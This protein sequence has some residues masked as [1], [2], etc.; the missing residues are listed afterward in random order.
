M[1]A[2]R[3]SGTL[4]GAA[5]K[6]VED[7]RFLLGK[8]GY[9]DDWQPAGLV[10]A[11][12]LRS[13]YAHARIAAIDVSRALAL[14]GVIAVVT[15]QQMGELARP[16]RA[17][18]TM[19]TYVA[20]EQPIL[21]RDKVR[22]VGEAVA[23]VVAHSRY[24]A[25]DALE[26]I[27]VE[28]DTLAAVSDVEAAAAEGS[29][30]VH[31][32]AATNVM[33]AREF[34]HGAASAGLGTGAHPEAAL[35][36]RERFRFRRHAAV[37]IEPRCCV[38]LYN[39]GLGELTLRS[40]TQCPGVVRTALAASL[41]MPEH[42]VRVVSS[43]VGGGFGAKSSVYPEE[44]AVSALAKMVGR[45]VN[46]TSDRR[47]DLLATSQAWDEIIDAELAVSAQGQILELKADV[48]ADVGAY[49]VYPWTLTIEPIQ[50]VSFL[51]GPY[52]VPN[53]WARARA[54]ATCKPAVGPYRG[55][56]RPIAAFVMEG[57]LERA[58]RRLKRDPVELRRLNY[59]RAD[60]FP[61]KTPTGIVWDRA[62]FAELLDQALARLNYQ[63][64]R[65]EQARARR[66]GRLVGIGLASFCELTGIGSGTPAAPGMPIPAGTEAATIRVDP[67]GT[68][69]AIFGV[70]SHGQGLETALAQVVADE[71]DVPLEDVRV[72]YGDTAF[73]PYGTGSYASRGAVMGGGAAILAARAL[74]EKANRIA[75]HL[76]E[77]APVLAK[78]GQRECGGIP[79][80]SMRDIAQAAYAGRKKLP[81][82]MEPGLEA[83]RFY[84]PFY[85]TASA[86]THAAVV[87]IDP[88]TFA[89]RVL[90]YVVAEDCGRIINPLIVEGQVVGGVAQGLGAALLEEMVYDEFGQPAT[91][92]LM[93]YMPPTASEIP[94]IEVEHVEQ[95][96]PTAL[97]GFRGVGES[98]TIGA[99]AAI[100]NA[101]A[102]ALAPLGVEPNELPITPARLFEL[103]GNKPS[104]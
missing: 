82:Q 42:L 88:Q 17:T 43:D 65:E 5:I 18:S 87:E 11:A 90:R 70:A 76:L 66:E 61:Y 77:T 103:C 47:E 27:V 86:A 91:A 39:A 74:R 92:S 67:S 3:N 97:G 98:G 37:S 21:A 80:V 89:V 35:T 100:A 52:H 54:V 85:G 16:L 6:R 63:Q 15:G 68:V 104:P 72:M 20:T 2:R 57:L 50:T 29:V 99:P 60:Q 83:T 36:V 102:D 14:D 95:P 1:A 34:K 31:E 22:F 62:P 101:V 73:A 10:Y 44:I 78:P 23:A 46:W 33:V 24:I 7:R 53:Y 93:D 8:G 69:T 79:R 81:A 12:F 59:V 55:V 41:A 25:E 94:R 9:A 19:R 13:P 26:L 4:V 48:L 56:G 51:T 96:S 40:S 84:D 45:P 75:A 64:A 71:L 58:A 32:D 49:A 30:L 28:Y 38:A